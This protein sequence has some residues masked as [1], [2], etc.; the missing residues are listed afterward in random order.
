[1]TAY[2]A[3]VM[4]NGEPHALPEPTTLAELLGR[5]GH[6]PA[7]VSTAVNGDFVPR[8]ARQEHVLADGDRVQCFQPIV[9]G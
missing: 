8:Q 2:A 4:V 3:R 9:G 1:M 7:S 5:L 6:T